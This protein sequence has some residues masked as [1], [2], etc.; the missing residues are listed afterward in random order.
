MKHL[1]RYLVAVTLCWKEMGAV[2][3]FPRP[4]EIRVNKFLRSFEMT[5]KP[6]EKGRKPLPHI[7]L[8]SVGRF[9]NIYKMMEDLKERF[10]KVDLQIPETSSDIISSF[11]RISW[12]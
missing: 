12:Y 2:D 1:D 7:F 5:I 11:R 3:A 10:G 4:S 6:N 9:Y 8:S